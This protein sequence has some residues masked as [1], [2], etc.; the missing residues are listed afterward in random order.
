MFHFKYCLYM[1]VCLVLNKGCVKTTFNVSLKKKGKISYAKYKKMQIYRNRYR[2]M[3]LQISDLGHH[4]IILHFQWK[5][6][7]WHCESLQVC[8]L[9]FPDQWDQDQT[10][11]LQAST[12]PSKI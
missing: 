12:A 8:Q 11:A 2:Q 3:I 7:M 9:V 10:C 4:F 6:Y 1:S 5:L